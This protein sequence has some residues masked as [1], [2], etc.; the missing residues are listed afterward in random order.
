MALKYF[1]IRDCFASMKWLFMNEISK[2]EKEFAEYIGVKHAIATSYG[3]TA[4]YLGLKAIGVSGKE[5]ILPSFTCTVVR[6]AVI[7]AGAIPKFVDIKINDFDFALEELKEKVTPLT[8]AIVIT[9]YFGDVAGNLE[10][11]LRLGKE[12]GIAVIEDCAHSLGAECKGKKIGTYGD[13]AIFSLTKGL[14]NFGGGVLVTNNDNL[15]YNARNL[16][17]KERTRYRKRF[18]DFPLVIS[19]GCEQIIDKLVFDR[20]KVSFF[21]WW[22]IKVPSVIVLA[23]NYLIL[24]TKKI[25]S[26]VNLLKKNTD[27]FKPLCQDQDVYSAELQNPYILEINRITASIGIS[28]LRKIDRTIE[29]RKSIYQEIAHKINNIHSNNKV[30]DTKSVYANIVLRFE[31]SDNNNIIIQCKEKGLLL[32]GTWPNHQRLFDEQDT[33]TVKKIKNEILI[34]NINPMLKE[35]EIC[36]FVEIINNTS[37]SP[38]MSD[39]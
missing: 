5:V 6:H 27:K 4:L 12:N 16:M 13:F 31:H 26:I 32:R 30:N 11:I 9:H 15:F 33:T 34:F 36:R 24:S 2:F 7:L 39:S 28:Q 3:R 21:K 10:A 20:V 35:Q 1:D 14:I 17:K 19:Y 29:K 18:V 38:F 25:G 23:R 22:A 8:K 37:G